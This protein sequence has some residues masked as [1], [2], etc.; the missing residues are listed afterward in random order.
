MFW[1]FLGEFRSEARLV[2]GLCV[3]EPPFKLDK[4]IV[5]EGFNCGSDRTASICSGGVISTL[6]GALFACHIND[7]VGQVILVMLVCRLS[8]LTPETTSYTVT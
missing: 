4:E 8:R 7:H 6:S 5:G 2:L 1:S 3:L